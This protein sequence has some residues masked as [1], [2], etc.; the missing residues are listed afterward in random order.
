MAR[1]FEKFTQM[2][3]DILQTSGVLSSVDGQ[4]DLD[5]IDLTL[6]MAELK[7][8]IGEI[9]SQRESSNA[10]SLTN[11]VKK[12]NFGEKEENKSLEL[13]QQTQSKGNEQILD[14]RWHAYFTEDTDPEEIKKVIRL[15]WADE[16]DKLNLSR[17]EKVYL[18]L[19]KQGAWSAYRVEFPRSSSKVTW[20]QKFWGNKS[21]AMIKGLA[22]TNRDTAI[23]DHGKPPNGLNKADPEE[24]AN[25]LA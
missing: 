14:R 6:K 22:V 9:L 18:S 4:E 19:V 12:L 23:G 3:E 24:P 20:S 1:D 7:G 25:E 2:A 16:Q 8:R 10:Q 13:T 15:V 17:S 11:A 21:A 5:L